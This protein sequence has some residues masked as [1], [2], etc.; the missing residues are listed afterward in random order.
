MRG[1]PGRSG[2][3]RKY[4]KYTI[5]GCLQWLVS[6]NRGDNFYRIWGGLGVVQ[7]LHVKD[8]LQGSEIG[9]DNQIP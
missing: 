2:N 9:I 6:S 5:D 1:K 4:K 7:G 8:L 3:S